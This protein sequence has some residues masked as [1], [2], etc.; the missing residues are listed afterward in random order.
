MKDSVERKIVSFE[1]RQMHLGDE[2]RN[3]L[4]LRTEHLTKGSSAAPIEQEQY[5]EEEQDFLEHRLNFSEIDATHVLLRKDA[6]WLGIMLT[7]FQAL[8][9][10]LTSAG[11][12][13]FGISVEGNPL[14]RLLMEE[15]GHIPVLTLL[16][17][18]A[19]TLVICMTLLA[20]RLP[21][22]RHAMVAVGGVYLLAAILPWTYILYIRPIL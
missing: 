13:R 7:V 16:K 9:G 11:I 17:S 8:D 15:F 6:V 4:W 19:I 20:N 2:A 18:A 14:L 3:W 10:F 22:I 5:I 1:K 21:W 12:D